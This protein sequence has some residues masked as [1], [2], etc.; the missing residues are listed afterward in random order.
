MPP[1]RRRKFADQVQA[2]GLSTDEFKVLSWSV[3]EPE[4][5]RGKTL[6]YE[7]PASEGLI[8]GRAVLS[9]RVTLF[10]GPK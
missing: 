7:Q 4:A 8:P 1:R 10:Y 9:A 5:P 2:L 3:Q 6:S